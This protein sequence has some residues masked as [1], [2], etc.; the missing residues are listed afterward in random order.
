MNS[1]FTERVD[2]I[3]QRT[4]SRTGGALGVIAMATDRNTNFY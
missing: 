1:R 3:L 4:A 2:Q